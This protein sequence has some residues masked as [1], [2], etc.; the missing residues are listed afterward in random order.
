M[1]VF[2]AW[3]NQNNIYNVG[4]T[5]KCMW[6][7][8]EFH[9]IFFSR[10]SIHCTVL[11]VGVVSQI[12]FLS[13][14]HPLLA[15]IN[16]QQDATGSVVLVGLVLVATSICSATLCH[17]S[18]TFLL[19]LLVLFATILYLLICFDVYLLHL[20]VWCHFPSE[21]DSLLW[22]VAWEIPK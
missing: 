8:H 20:L 3:V 1:E 22:T 5:K 18:A 12:F 13:F 19:K 9:A 6:V 7:M 15:P 2:G 21:T 16:K 17:L 14:I 10:P 11:P 4:N